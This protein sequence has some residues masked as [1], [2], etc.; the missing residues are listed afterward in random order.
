MSAL[1][2]NLQAVQRFDPS[3][4]HWH[5]FRTEHGVWS[6]LADL[7]PPLQPNVDFLLTECLCRVHPVHRWRLRENIWQSQDKILVVSKQ[8]WRGLL[9]FG[10]CAFHTCGLKK[11]GHEYKSPSAH[12][13]SHVWIYCHIKNSWRQS[14]IKTEDGNWIWCRYKLLHT[15]VHMDAVLW[16]WTVTFSLWSCLH[17]SLNLFSGTNSRIN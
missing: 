4:R 3:V 8:L 5:V 10:P 1:S 13:K 15:T 14:S 12:E 11:C 16:T 6:R 17:K 2:R 7:T 9:I